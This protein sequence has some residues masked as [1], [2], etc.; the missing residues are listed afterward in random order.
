MPCYSAWQTEDKWLSLQITADK[1]ILFIQVSNSY[2]GCIRTL[3]NKLLTSKEDKE[4]HGLGLDSVKDMIKKYN[5]DM[6]IICDNSIFTEDILLY[7]T[8]ERG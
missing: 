3:D 7:L 6:K 5:G 8:V 1:G 4:N 2:C